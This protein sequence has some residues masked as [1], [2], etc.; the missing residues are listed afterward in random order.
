MNPRFW[1]NEFRAAVMLVVTNVITAL[2][3]FQI[4]DWSNDQVAAVEG[5]VNSL[6][7]LLFYVLRGGPSMQAQESGKVSPP[8]V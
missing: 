8:A 7:I 6:T 4:V 1:S 5:V 2:V 3:L